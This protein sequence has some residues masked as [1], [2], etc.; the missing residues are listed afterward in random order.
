MNVKND[1]QGMDVKE[2]MPV[3]SENPLFILIVEDHELIRIG[4]CEILRGIHFG[5][6]CISEADSFA[7]A[8]VRMNDESQPVDLVLLDLNLPDSQGIDTLIRFRKSYPSVAISLLTG[9]VDR[10][11]LLA[12]YDVGISGFISKASSPKVMQAAVKLILNGGVYIPREIL[13]CFEPSTVMASPL[14]VHPEI[15][16]PVAAPSEESGFFQTRIRLTKRQLE[17]A[18]LV[19][20]GMS[21][22]EISR[23]LDMAFGTVKNHVAA[24]LRLL[25]TNSRAK[26]ISLLAKE[27]SL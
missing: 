25:G 21:N 2:E 16:P 27:L 10:E 8:E 5:T 7:A 6:V 9:V 18:E 11:V 12:A 20:Q 26:A 17:V 19:C 3:R 23:R 1:K 14:A 24:I 15:E 13:S 22:K 4:L